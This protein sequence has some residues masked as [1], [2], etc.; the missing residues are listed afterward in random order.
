MSHQVLTLCFAL[1]VCSV[2]FH[3]P[4]TSDRVPEPVRNEQRRLF[5][6]VPAVAHVAAG[7]HRRRRRL[8]LRLP[9]PVLHG[10]RRPHLHRQLHGRTAPLRRQGKRPSA[11]IS[12]SQQVAADQQLNNGS[13]ER[14]PFSFPARSFCASLAR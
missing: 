13:Y 5:E 7:R 11:A 6:P 2:F 8:P 14:N 9:Q 12:R 3:L 1:V 4:M 10:A